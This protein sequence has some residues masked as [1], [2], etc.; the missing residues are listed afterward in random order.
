MARFMERFIV[1]I[2]CAGAKGSPARETREGKAEFTTE[3]RR[4]GGGPKSRRKIKAA[5]RVCE[6]KTRFW[7]NGNAE[8]SG[9]LERQEQGKPLRRNQGWHGLVFEGAGGNLL[10]L[11]VLPEVSR[12][13][14]RATPFICIYSAASPGS[15]SPLHTFLLIF[16][17]IDGSASA[18]SQSTG[19]RT[20][21]SACPGAIDRPGLEQCRRGPCWSKTRFL[22]NRPCK[23]H[24]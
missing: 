22:K 9:T 14:V 4:R 13:P 3:T 5:S 11:A 12:R 10:P 23:C 8:G 20:A 21:F 6:K 19:G 7:G 1:K 17:S 24:W 16:F 2:L 18:L 15:V